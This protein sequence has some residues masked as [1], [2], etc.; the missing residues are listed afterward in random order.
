MS[1]T[2]RRMRAFE[3]EVLERLDKLDRLDEIAALLRKI[4]G[5]EKE[6]APLA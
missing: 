5:E 3:Q 6:P 1:N 2:R 4:A